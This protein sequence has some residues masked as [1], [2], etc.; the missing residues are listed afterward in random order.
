MEI[1]IAALA[2]L[3]VASGAYL[4]MSGSSCRICSA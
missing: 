1:A 2:G 4:M 3:L